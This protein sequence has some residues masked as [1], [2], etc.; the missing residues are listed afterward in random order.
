MKNARCSRTWDEI[1][2]GDVL[3]AIELEVSYSK[4]VGVTGAAWDYFPGHH[5]PDYARAQGQKTIYLN[6]MALSGFLDRIVLDWVGPAWFLRRRSMRMSQPVYAGEVLVGSGSVTDKGREPDGLPY[7][8]VALS[9]ATSAG[10]CV[11]GRSTVVLFDER[12]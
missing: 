4:V 12:G 3:P 5:D 2:E 6:T 1:A 9:A 8:E 10:E 11:T 7:I